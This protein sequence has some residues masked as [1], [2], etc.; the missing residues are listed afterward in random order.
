MIDV[1][2]LSGLVV[3]AGGRRILDGVELVL[4]PGEF[5]AVVG[6]NGAGKST[7]LKA[8]LG[9]IPVGR[10][11]VSLGKDLLHEL[12]PA[13][14]AE[15]LAWL[16]QRGSLLEPIPVLERVAASRYRFDEARPEA[17]VAAQA[18]LDEVGVGHLAERSID[19][20]SGGEF[21]RVAVASLLAQ[22]ARWWMLDE[23]ANHL[24]P[25]QQ[26]AIYRFLGARWRAGQSMVCVTHDINLLGHLGTHADAGLRIIGIR[27][28]G[29]AFDMS[30]DDPALVMALSQLFEI[31]VT[32][33]ELEGRIQFAVSAEEHH[34]DG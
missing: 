27:G 6:P 18:A 32:M 15:R 34:A 16:P 21:Q 9:L 3:N 25:A 33:F 24:D 1:L 10:G 29:V 26:V 12:A 23:P 31:S 30:F 2:L 13:E 17:L 8:S 4:K 20:L 14:R 28:G 11:V 22:R 7:L 19:T 5:V